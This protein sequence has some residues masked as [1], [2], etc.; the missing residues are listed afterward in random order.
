MISVSMY[1]STAGSQPFLSMVPAA[2]TQ[3]SV[4][5]NGRRRIASA[6]GFSMSLS[7]SSVITPRV[8][9]LPIMS[10]AP[11][12]LITL[13]SARTAVPSTI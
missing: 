4:S 11:L 3:V 9:S 13:P 2:F 7:V 5:M 1:S 12:S 10:F 6:L 8:P